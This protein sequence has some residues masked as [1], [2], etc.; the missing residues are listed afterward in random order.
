VAAQEGEAAGREGGRTICS[1]ADGPGAGGETFGSQQG[2][3]CLRRGFVFAVR[4]KSTQTEG[5]IG[6]W[7]QEQ[8]NHPRSSHG[9]R[10]AA[11]RWDDE[12]EEEEEDGEEEK[13]KDWG[14]R[15][16]KEKDQGPGDTAGDET[17][18][19]ETGKDC[20]GQE[21]AMMFFF[22]LL[23]QGHTYD[24]GERVVGKS[25]RE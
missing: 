3:E 18:D 24:G 8:M 19:E 9:E 11:E 14:E 1:S 5:P 22:F 12:E 20:K 4:T 15:E 10:C 17:G 7:S 2:R 16:G 25:S 23:E 6:P 13:E 21:D